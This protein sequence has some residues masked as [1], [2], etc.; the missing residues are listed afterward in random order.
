M[1]RS[2]TTKVLS[3]C[4][5][6]RRP[7][8][9]HIKANSASAAHH[10]S[11]HFPGP[12]RRTA[13]GAK[14]LLVG[15]LIIP[16]SAGAILVASQGPSQ[17]NKATGVTIQASPSSQVISLNDS[18]IY[19]VSLTAN[20]DFSGTISPTVSGLPVH[21][22]A[23]FTPTTVQ[24]APGKTATILLTVM[25]SDSPAQGQAELTIATAASPS[26]A[27]GITVQLNVQPST[28]KTFAFSGDLDTP[29]SPGATVPLN[30]SISNPNNKTLTLNSLSVSIT[31]I[32]R[33]EAALAA[34]LPCT[35][36]D[37]TVSNYNGH[38]LT[39]PGGHSSLQSLEIPPALWPKISMLDTFLN[40]DGCKGATLSLAYSQA[41]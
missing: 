31:G 9:L 17:G 35:R 2:L 38:P 32:R 28:N 1:V 40:Q 30:V 16:T 27:T 11:R 3:F 26:Q 20:N 33:T 12:T 8:V 5:S 18:V 36:D 34:S 41:Q 29:L 25:T 6:H 4:G 24:L 39:I 10:T 15:L 37:Y 19:P 14:A 7:S 22:T 21:T 23:A 13:T